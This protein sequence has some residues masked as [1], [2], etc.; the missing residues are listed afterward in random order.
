M[1]PLNHINFIATGGVSLD[2]LSEIL[3]MGF[4]GAG[5]GEYLADKKLIANGNIAELINRASKFVEISKNS[6]ASE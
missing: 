4:V 2:N 1:S 3:N 6:S 5:I